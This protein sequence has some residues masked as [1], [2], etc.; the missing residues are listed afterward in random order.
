TPKASHHCSP[1]S[2]SSCETPPKS[3][4]SPSGAVSSAAPIASRFP[5]HPP[6]PRPRQKSISPDSPSPVPAPFP[7]S[8]RLLVPF[9]SPPVYLFFANSLT[10]WERLGKHRESALRWQDLLTLREIPSNKGAAGRRTPAQFCPSEQ[11]V[12]HHPPV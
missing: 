10:M 5:A 9:R 1:A 8:P 2:A 6:A 3:A 7:F 12:P 4:F 11:V